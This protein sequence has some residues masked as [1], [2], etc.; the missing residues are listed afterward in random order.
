[1]KSIA[2]SIEKRMNKAWGTGRT[3]PSLNV[4]RSSRKGGENGTETMSEERTADNYLFLMKGI[5]ETQWI[6]HGK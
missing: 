2:N 3:C 4:N 1:M 5:Q 6:C